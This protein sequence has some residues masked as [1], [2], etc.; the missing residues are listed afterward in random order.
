MVIT[1]KI[2]GSLALNCHPTGCKEEVLNQ[3]KYI[4]CAK[5]YSGAKKVLIIG[6]SSGYGLATRIS[7][8]FGGSNADTIGVS[9]EREGSARKVGSA[10]WYSNI[11]FR[12]EA[13][14]KGL[15]AKNILGDAFSHD[16]KKNVIKYIKEEFGGKIDLLVYSLASGMRTDP[17]TNEV[18]KSNLRPQGE[19]LTGFTFNV[20]KEC[21]EE[22][23][24]SPATEEDLAN[25]VK[26]MGGEDW[27]LWVKALMEAD[28]VSEGFKTLAYSYIGPAVMEGIYRHGTIGSAKEHLEKTARDLDGI[29]KDTKSGEAYVAVNKAIVT[30][31]SAYIPIFPLYASALMRVM[32]EKGI[33]ENAI[34][35]THRLFADMVYGDKPEFDSEKRMRPDS[36]ELRDDVQEEV[37][38]IYKKVTE[39]NF[40]ELT[41][42][43]KYK[44]EF[45]KLNGFSVEGVDY[46]EDVDLEKLAEL[47]P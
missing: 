44:T 2:K 46:E 19:P 43:D 17:D 7:L 41:D 30:K 18:Y 29:L 22:V 10:G 42:F 47:K 26:V 6:A 33:E 4:E 5:K 34:E 1:P 16:M 23:T 37:L 13:E 40:K 32:E 12:E 25:T 45:L 9:F 36:W 31:A 24:L 8:A 15:I 14:K 20:E 38:E 21:M 35:H 27:E 39:D 28:V 3:I 11:W